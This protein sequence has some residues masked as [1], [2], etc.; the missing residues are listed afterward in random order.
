[1]EEKKIILSGLADVE[2]NRAIAKI[3]GASHLL[4][5]SVRMDKDGVGFTFLHERI[6]VD[7]S[8]IEYSGYIACP[9]PE[10]TYRM[11]NYLNLLDIIGKRAYEIKWDDLPDK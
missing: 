4:V 10:S 9:T 3:A 2:T 1:M 11:I 8:E 6:N 5:Y 7:T